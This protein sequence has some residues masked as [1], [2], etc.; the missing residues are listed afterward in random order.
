MTPW[1][2]YFLR[3]DPRPAL[4]L[5]RV[6]VLALNG[7][8]DVQVDAEQ[9]L[10]AIETALEKGGNR[11]VTTHSLPGVNHLFQTA[12]TGMVDEYA[13]IEE[14]MAPSVLD[15]IRDWILAQT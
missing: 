3:H 14:T 8:L 13:M 5:T 2:R 10:P 11:T 7:D 4:L 9:N 15:L 1:L 6:P 12:G